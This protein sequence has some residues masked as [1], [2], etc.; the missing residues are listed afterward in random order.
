MIIIFEVLTNCCRFVVYHFLCSC[1]FSFFFLIITS[2]NYFCSFPLRFL[3]SLYFHVSFHSSPVHVNFTSIPLSLSSL[4]FF[5]YLSFLYYT[6][7]L[8]ISTPLLNLC[9]LSYSALCPF[10]LTFPYAASSFLLH[11]LLRP[12]A[13]LSTY[14]LS[15]FPMYLLYP[16]FL[17]FIIFSFARPPPFLHSIESSSSS[18]HCRDNDPSI[19][20]N[21]FILLQSRPP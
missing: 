9:F 16:P 3:F 12:F 1:H 8:L 13:R 14:C 4:L 2:A 20:F 17:F 19:T 11:P 7:F 21:C 5:S 15:P 18:R 6:L 10:F